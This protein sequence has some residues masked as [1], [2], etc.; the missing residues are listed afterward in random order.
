[1][2]FATGDVFH[3]DSILDASS[4]ACI[5][6]KVNRYRIGSHYQMYIMN[7]LIKRLHHES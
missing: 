3:F 7:R 1:M 2:S 6:N 5:E 4:V